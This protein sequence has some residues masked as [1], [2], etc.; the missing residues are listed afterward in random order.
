MS[1]KYKLPNEWLKQSDYDLAT[2]KSMFDTG[3]YIYTVF[4]CH[5]SIEKMLKGLYAK[6]LETNPP[7]T[8]SLTY[9]CEMLKLEMPEE[10]QD[11]IDKL[12]NL[13]VPT[14]YPEKLDKL[15]KDFKKALTEDVYEQAKELLQWLKKK[16]I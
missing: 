3:R 11:F 10:F 15:L 2:A 14:R 7:K 12:D 8:H 5:L 16:M 4:M 1:G 6:T 9:L 13:S